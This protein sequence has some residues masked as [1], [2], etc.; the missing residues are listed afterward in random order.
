MTLA[1]LDA[2]ALLGRPNRA[3]A[4]AATVE[5]LQDARVL[6]TGAGGSIGAHLS[7]VLAGKVPPVMFAVEVWSSFPN[8]TLATR[9]PVKP[10]YQASR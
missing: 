8:Q 2:A 4:V 6:I 9:L 5:T 1:N 7:R 3:D 10:I